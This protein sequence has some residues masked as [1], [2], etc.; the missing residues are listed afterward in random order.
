MAANTAF[1]EPA[2]GRPGCSVMART[3]A[4]QRRAKPGLLLLDDELRIAFSEPSAIVL[5][6]QACGPVCDQRLPQEIERSIRD[7]LAAAQSAENQV[8]MPVPELLIRVSGLSGSRGQFTALLVE[9]QTRRS[10]LVAASKRFAF[11]KRETDVLR[12]LLR[13]SATGDVARELSIS[14][15]TATGYFKALLR[16][17]GSHSRSEMVA[18]VLGW[19]DDESAS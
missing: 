17:T 19:D 10:S 2:G 13:G 11:S 8:V 4:V 16:K 12:L 15:A 1:V 3:D 7:V 9:K 6:Q 5:I 14:E 18:K